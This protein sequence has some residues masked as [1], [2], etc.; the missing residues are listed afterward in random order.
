MIHN[1]NYFDQIEDYCHEQ[2]EEEFRLEFEA[3]LMRNPEL[4]NEL[5][6]WKEIQSAIGEKEVLTLR[7]KLEN[8][9]KEIKPNE[10]SDESFELLDEFSDIQEINEILSSKE[11]IDFYDS[12]PKVHAYHHEANSNENIHQFYKKQKNAEFFDIEEDESDFEL[13]EFE[14][15]EEAILEKDILQFR[16]TLQ[17]VAKSVEPQYTVEEIDNYLSGELTGA[18]LL[19][20]ETDI[21]QDRSLKDEVLLH[22]EINSAVEENDIMD[23]RGQISNILQTETSWN[24]SEKDIEDFIDGVLEGK[25]L[26]EFKSE[27]NDNT[28][29]FAEVELRKQ[30]N[31][32]LSEKDV[33]ELRSKLNSA[34]ESADVKRVKMLIPE[35][36]SAKMKFWRSSVAILIVL[37][38]IAGVLRNNF[39]SIDRMYDNSYETPSWSPERSLTSEVSIMQKANISYLDADWNGVIDIFNEIPESNSDNPVFDF[40]RAAS[41]QNLSN[42]QEAIQ[43]YTKV[44]KN[45]DNLFVEEAEWYRSLCYLKL[46]NYE[47]ARKELVAVRDRKGYFE[48][49]AKAV[50]RR[51]KYSIK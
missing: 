37:I 29:L 36:R 10:L 9:A 49:D 3:E 8:V 50:I 7:N 25:S 35:T 14:G 20:F 33:F 39:T 40:Y 41:L 34:R 23:L 31:N 22:Q 21:V 27:L 15:L 51:L 48:Q 11:L 47:M 19:E 18:E 24:V 46:E 13:E 44:I 28:D 12:L 6:L 5:E 26:E 17:Q 42:F 1:T 16:Q 30:V 43:G 4:K 32:A 45:G 2:L 38:G